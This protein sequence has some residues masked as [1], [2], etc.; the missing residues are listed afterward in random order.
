MRLPWRPLPQSIS[1]VPSFP[2]PLFPFSLFLFYLSLL[3]FSIPHALLTFPV[4]LFSPHP[5]PYITSFF[6]FFYP[7]FLFPSFP[8]PSCLILSFFFFCLFFFSSS[9]SSFPPSSPRTVSFL[10]F[11]FSFLPS[12]HLP[13]FCSFFLFPLHLFPSFSFFLFFPVLFPPF[14]PLLIYIMRCVPFL[15]GGSVFY[16]HY[17]VGSAFR[18]F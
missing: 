1:P 11:M 15:R 13:P 14:R 12:S 8:S 5:L 16:I 18:F 9:S 3:Y 17:G 2:F 6:S 7:L 4:V 10:L